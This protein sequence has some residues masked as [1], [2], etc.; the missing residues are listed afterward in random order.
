VD[1]INTSA[2]GLSA[3][4]KAWALDAGIDVDEAMHL[5]CE[6][7][8]TPSATGREKMLAQV[9]ARWAGEQGFR[10]R[11]QPLGPDR[12][13]V[14]VT[15]DGSGGGGSLLFNGHLDT[16]STGEEKHLVGLGYK[17]KAIVRD[18]WLFGLGA[19]NM[20]SGLA[21][22]LMALHTISRSGKIFN[23][24]IVVAG[25]AGEVEKACI[26]DFQGPEYTGYGFGT[27]QLL[28]HGVCAE[29]AIVCEPTDFRPSHG[30][31]GAL[32]VKVTLSGDMKH[33]A[34]FDERT[35]NHAIYN[36]ARVI[37]AIRI[38]GR[39]YQARN[40]YHDQAACIHVG[41]VAGG[42]PWRISR[43]PNSCSLYVDIRLTPLQRPEAVLREFKSVV[44]AALSEIRS[45]PLATFDPY[46]ISP[47]I[48]ARGNEPVFEAIGEA[49]KEAFGNEPHLL[50]RGP[51][52]DAGHINAA[53]IPAVTYGLGPAGNF[54]R[55]NPDT[56]EGGEQIRVADYLML[57]GIY[58]SAA[59][60]LCGAKR[61]P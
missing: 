28:A 47:S 38:W 34:F 21:A 30:Q 57:I 15:L 43:T 49:H 9:I 16:S 25:V 53:G 37:E 1:T 19:V 42:W 6:M 41:A 52:A 35:G 31:L 48:M 40:T 29:S 12:A 44:L 2:Q 3:E 54:D 18:G 58:A 22:A 33:T 32:W 13:N 46:V 56:G 8:N 17:P 7:I 45:E 5:I 39:D 61:G 14:I 24:D 4:I 23:G 11:L 20:K 27:V 26:D 55:V 60:Q 50:F 51:M 10:A 59:R 36:A